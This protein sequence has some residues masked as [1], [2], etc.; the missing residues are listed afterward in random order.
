M[1]DRNNGRI[2]VFE[3]MGDHK[4]V[5]TFGNF[6]DCGSL[7][8]DRNGYIFVCDERSNKIYVS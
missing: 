7:T 3:S 4:L 5:A 6:H 2:V 8:M 1:A